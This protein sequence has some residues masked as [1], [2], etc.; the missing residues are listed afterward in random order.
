MTQ[1]FEKWII[2]D[3]KFE[4]SIALLRESVNNQRQIWEVNFWCNKKSTMT[5]FHCSAPSLKII[6]DK[7][8]LRNR[9]QFHRPTTPKKFS[10]FGTEIFVL[11]LKTETVF[12]NG[13]TRWWL[14]HGTTLF[15]PRSCCSPCCHP[16]FNSNYCNICKLTSTQEW[17]IT[18]EV[19][20]RED[21]CFPLDC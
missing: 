18:K 17:E 20:S 8:A 3:D 12:G 21:S 4:I 13:S 9:F 1:K 19:I 6:K 11:V 10:R 15:K 16:H 14:R 2:D 5:N 7:H